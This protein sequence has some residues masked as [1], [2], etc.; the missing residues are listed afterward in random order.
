MLIV[1]LFLLIFALVFTTVIS[2]IFLNG[3]FQQEQAGFVRGSIQAIMLTLMLLF[4]SIFI[5]T[6]SFLSLSYCF[7]RRQYYFED[8]RVVYFNQIFGTEWGG[9][10]VELREGDMIVSELM[11]EYDQKI[12]YKK[13][14]FNWTSQKQAIRHKF[15]ISLLRE[16]KGRMVLYSTLM[17]GQADSFVQE[18]LARYPFITLAQKA[19]DTIDHSCASDTRIHMPRKWGILQTVSLGIMLG[20]GINMGM[21]AHDYQ[22]PK[23]T[24]S[25]Q[26]VQAHLLRTEERSSGS[27]R[28]RSTTV[29][30]YYAYVYG[31]KSYKSEDIKVSDVKR[32]KGS[33]RMYELFVRKDDPSIHAIRPYGEHSLLRASTLY[34]LIMVV[35]T[36]VFIASCIRRPKISQKFV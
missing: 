18:F 30:G 25:W 8:S 29:Y 10:E 9:H 32:Y 15:F 12:K 2:I 34:G 28:S 13:S 6:G 36:Y 17:K 23:D 35:A 22:Y 33:A 11:P 31:G 26:S 21:K 4:L 27:G 3:I 24:S 1:G 7:G 5:F 19:P 20:A 14:M 16:G